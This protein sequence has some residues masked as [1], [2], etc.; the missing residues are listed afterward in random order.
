VSGKNK[1]APEGVDRPELLRGV[2]SKWPDG[3]HP[4]GAQTVSPAPRTQRAVVH[5]HSRVCRVRNFRPSLR[6][7][8]SILGDSRR[9]HS[10]R[11]GSFEGALKESGL[12]NRDD[13]ATQLV[14]K[15]IIGVAQQGERDPLRLREAGV[16][17]FLIRRFVRRRPPRKGG[18]PWVAGGRSCK[19][20]ALLLGRVPPAKELRPL[21]L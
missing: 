7:I 15:R 1:A 19:R 5:R 4:F 8:S 14:A 18:C 10:M 16:E 13:P 6:M 9:A 2:A 20:S 3:S 17:L 12:V 21:S 11:G